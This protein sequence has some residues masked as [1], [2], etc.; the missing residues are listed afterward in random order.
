MLVNDRKI[1]EENPEMGAASQDLRASRVVLVCGCLLALLLVV[2]CVLGLW[3][4]STETL[5]EKQG[6]LDRLALALAEQTERSFESIDLVIKQ[7]RGEIDRL[8][9]TSLSDQAA[10]HQML[11]T[12]IF[13]LPQAQALL[14]FDPTGSM[15]GHSRDYP[16]PRINSADRD[17]FV[18]QTDMSTDRDYISRPLRNRVNGRW[19]ISVSR[20]IKAAGTDKFGGIVMAAIEVE[21]F[22]KLYRALDLPDGISIILKRL[23]GVVLIEYPANSGPAQPDAQLVAVSTSPATQESGEASRPIISSVKTIPELNLA[24]ILS[25]PKA[26]ALSLCL[27]LAIGISCATILAVAAILVMTLLI[28][29]QVAKLEN[30][31]RQ[32][33]D[34]RDKYH[35]LYDT[36][37]DAYLIMEIN[38]GLI[39]ECNRAAEIMLRGGREHIIGLTPTHF[40][41]PYQPGGKASVDAV[42]KIIEECLQ[43]GAHRFE[44]VHRRLDG[45]DFW[46]EVS[47][48]VTLY[49]GRQVLFVAWR[50]ITDRKASEEQ[51][52]EAR[53]SAET[54]NQAK[55][56]FL[57]MMSHELRTPMNAILGLAYLLERT[58]LDAHQRDYVQKTRISARSLLGIVNDILDLS[59]VE[60]GKLD[61]I[62]EPFRLDDLMK[63]LATIAA[64]NARDK[65]IEVLF[66]IS[67]GTPL[68]LVGDGLRIQ[69]VLTNLAGNAIK[70]TERGEVV[71]SV[72]A[73]ATDEKYADLLFSV[74]D[75]GVGIAPENQ[76]AIF[77][78][79]SQADNT[80]S[81][82]FGGT[83]LGLTICRRLVELVGGRI[84]CESE[85]GKGS[86][87]HVAIRFDR[88]GLFE[89]EPEQPQNTPRNLKVLVADDN[90][91]ARQIMTAMVESFGWTVVLASSGRQALEE[92]DLAL[93]AEPFDLLLLDW[94]MPELGGN[95]IV[96]HIKNQNLSKDIPLVVVV[97]AYESE[98]VHRDSG[99]E[100]LIRAV[101][102][103]PVTP[104]ILL[105]A[106]ILARQVDAN[107][108][109]ASGGV[110]QPPSGA[111]AS[112]APLS[113]LSLLVVE[114]NTI[115]QVVARRILEASGAD[116]AVAGD[117]IMALELLSTGNN[118]YDAVLMD[119]QMPGMDGYET[120]RTIRHE[121]GMVELPIIAMTANAM[122]SDRESCL[123]VGMNDHIGKPFEVTQ[124]IAVITKHIR[125]R[126]LES[127][128]NAE[129]PVTVGDL[130]AEIET[131]SAINTADALNRAMDDH[132]L[133]RAIMREFAITYADVADVIARLV[134]NG[135]L[136]VVGKVAHD[137]KGVAANLGAD[138][139]AKATLAL[140]SAAE[141]GNIEQARQACN[142]IGIL[143][144]TVLSEARRI[145]DGAS[146]VTALA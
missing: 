144:P 38:G 89:E 85:P 115:N 59:K 48:S 61:L 129:P 74:R 113:G 65:D 102:T 28:N 101:L 118:R 21:Y 145:A 58:N 18:S 41:P 4:L 79:F 72:Q 73:T 128:M 86:T 57:A 138:Q 7:A 12:K 16:T 63:S 42:A 140:Q 1:A 6:S 125:P 90:P 133:L 40:S 105:D 47:I 46:A 134:A 76:L 50:D 126:R 93:E 44:W 88:T 8:G 34:L 112:A 123:A 87:F 9:P 43:Y 132:E 116:V 80:T 136:A 68:T 97:T 100:R 91:T 70:F 49:E 17:Y 131:G 54:A 106:V 117:G 143:L 13:G 2:G 45:T 33:T 51:L 24:I 75:T 124:M 66:D 96:R 60:A 3:S 142:D 5:V 104:S 67:P 37:P 108:D 62:L 120:T 99:D 109:M 71:L 135:E 121:L 119:I 14:V 31:E 69:Q 52:I 95:E 107:T 36:S 146:G 32:I 94:V 103:K 81:R 35:L 22:T 84:W 26:N 39:S 64:A 111:C 56:A 92:I 114:D 137:L 25:L 78:A 77:D 141:S 83:G 122:A 11:K 82:R 15:V 139:L 10:L 23:D 130:P 29:K 20:H 110:K 27:R 55:S 98:R 127:S 19:M 53:Q 30:R